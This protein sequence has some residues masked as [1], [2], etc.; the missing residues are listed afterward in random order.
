MGGKKS[1]VESTLVSNKGGGRNLCYDGGSRLFAVG[2]LSTIAKRFGIWDM[3]TFA[4][5]RKSGSILGWNIHLPPSLM[6]TRGT[7]GFDHHSQMGNGALRASKGQPC[8]I[9]NLILGSMKHRLRKT[10][11]ASPWPLALFSFGEVSFFETS[12]TK[13]QGVDDAL[14]KDGLDRR[15]LLFVHLLYTK[16]SNSDRAPEKM[17]I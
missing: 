7:I 3:K 2:R 9:P 15:L 5:F 12:C 10:E 4:G 14:Q 6:F 16:T 17:P 1:Y 11:T 8:L 13:K